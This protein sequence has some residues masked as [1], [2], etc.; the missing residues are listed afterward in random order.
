MQESVMGKEDG[1]MET[2]NTARKCQMSL[3]ILS[4]QTFLATWNV[5]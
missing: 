1:G 5:K 3:I 2:L 4:V